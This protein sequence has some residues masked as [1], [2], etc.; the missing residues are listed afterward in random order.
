MGRRRP[1]PVRDPTRRLAPK[2]ALQRRTGVAA[3]SNTRN[4]GA[5]T[6]NGPFWAAK[7]P[8]HHRCRLVAFAM[9]FRNTLRLALTTFLN[10]IALRHWI[11]TV[12]VVGVRL[13]MERT[14]R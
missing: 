6:T 2:F 12:I 4:Y 11:N 1:R 5:D 8:T 14:M 9:Q 3:R 10:S 13:C 7:L